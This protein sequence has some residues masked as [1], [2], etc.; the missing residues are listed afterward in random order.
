MQQPPSRSFTSTSLG[1]LLAVLKNRCAVSQ[2][3]DPI[4]GQQ[5]PGP[6]IVE[7]EAIWDTGATNS[8]I[9][10]DVIDA[11]ALAPIGMVQTHGVHGSAFAEVYLVNIYLPNQVM[12][13]S[14]RV[15]KGILP[16]AQILIGMDLIM[17]GDFAVTNFQGLTKF[18]FRVPSMRHIDFVQEHH[19]RELRKQHGA[20]KK[21]RPKQG[22]T[23][24]INKHKKKAG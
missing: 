16:D 19:D 12:F 14:I 13:H 3:F 5:Q 24:G 15:T 7:F 4:G 10:Q 17:Q 9:T 6:P 2:A 11:C 8:V 20:K 1:G 21:D 23:F 18:S 22:K